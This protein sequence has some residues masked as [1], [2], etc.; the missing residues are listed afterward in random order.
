MR[1][2]L[3][4]ALVLSSGP[5]RALFVTRLEGQKKAKTLKIPTHITID[6]GRTQIAAST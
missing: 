1:F 3:C 2:E 6:A 4:V 5:D